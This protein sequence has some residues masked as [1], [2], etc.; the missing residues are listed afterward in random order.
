MRSGFGSVPP[1]I[2]QLPSNWESMD[3]GRMQRIS[4][5]DMYDAPAVENLSTELLNA[6]RMEL[7]LSIIVQLSVDA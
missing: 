5:H 4:K 6:M 3:N 7:G 2:L 1:R